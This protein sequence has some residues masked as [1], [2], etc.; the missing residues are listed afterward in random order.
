MKLEKHNSKELEILWRKRDSAKTKTEHKNAQEEIDKY[1]FG[2]PEK[3]EKKKKKRKKTDIEE[4]FE[5]Y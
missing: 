5:L 3:K 2:K 1:F 4:E